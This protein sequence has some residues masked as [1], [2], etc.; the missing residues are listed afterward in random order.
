MLWIRSSTYVRADIHRSSACYQ[1]AILDAIQ[2]GF[3]MGQN[4]ANSQ[5]IGSLVDYL[6]TTESQKA[7]DLYDQIETDLDAASKSV[8]DK[9]ANWVVPQKDVDC[10]SNNAGA[11]KYG[12][13]GLELCSKKGDWSDVSPSPLGKNAANPGSSCAALK[14]AGVS[15]GNGVYWLIAGGKTSLTYCNMIGDGVAVGDGTTKGKSAPSCIQLQHMYGSLTLEFAKFWIG[16][17]ET[18]CGIKYNAVVG[19][20]NGLSQAAAAPSC[21]LLLD[22]WGLKNDD[23]RWLQGGTKI[24]K[25]K[26]EG[27]TATRSASLVCD[28]STT[29]DGGDRLPTSCLEVKT[30]CAGA[31]NGDYTIQKVGKTKVKVTCDIS[32]G[33]WTRAYTADLKAFAAKSF[34]TNAGGSTFNWECN[35][36]YSYPNRHDYELWNNFDLQFDFTSVKGNIRMTPQCGGINNGC[37]TGGAN[38]DNGW[39]GFQSDSSYSK[40]GAGGEGGGNKNWHRWG[41]PGK[42]LQGG[43]QLGWNGQWTGG[44]RTTTSVAFTGLPNQSVLRFSTGS[45]S[46]APG[47]ERF[48]YDPKLWVK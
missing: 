39:Y 19:V 7:D 16:G 33:G 28:K 4:T 41:V 14:S 27:K 35:S 12:A 13:K 5:S 29:A 44:S 26:V 8:E 31:G 3:T 6:N 25:C 48:M 40:L 11:L 2:L 17:A 45:E 20:A 18:Y 34:Q 22:T 9:L 38:P 32:G 21:Q 24:G 23:K 42:V 46:G 10:G 30:K 47:C 36:F 1:Q 43:P 15:T 37:G